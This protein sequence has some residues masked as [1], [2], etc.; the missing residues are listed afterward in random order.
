MKIGLKLILIISAVNLVGIG[1]L[2]IAATV[3]SSREIT[4][5][6]DLDVGHLTEVTAKEVKAFLE[7]PL[8][9][10]R[11]MVNLMSAIDEIAPPEGRREQI[12]F[13]LHTMIVKHPD[14]VGVW[15]IYEP[16]ALDGRDAA[17]VNSEWSDQTG[18][19]ISYWTNDKGVIG[20][21]AVTGYTTAEYYTV[22]MRTGREYLVEPYIE[23]IGGRKTLITSVT[24]PIIVAGKIVG[25]AGV[26]LEL[27]EIQEMIIK[28]KPFGDGYA[29][30]Y[31]SG[32]LI[33]S[34]P[35]ADRLGRKIEDASKGL[36]GDRT[37]AL[38]RS[39]KEGVV[40]SE[41]LYSSDHN[42]R[43]IVVTRP[44]TTGNDQD[45]WMAV[46]VVP[47]NTVMAE[48]RRMTVFLAI[49]GVAILGI[50]TVIILFVA[51]SITAP[52]NKME[53]VFE[54]IGNGDFTHV[55]E[56]KGNDEIGNISRSLNVT[57][58]KIKA[59]INV[60]KIQASELSGIGTDLSSNMTETAAAINEI[61]ANIQSIKTRAINQSASV[62]ETNAT[63]EQI[64]I[65]ISKLNEQVEKQTTSVSQ[66]SSAIEEMLANIQSVTQTL[67]KNMENVNALTSASEVGRSGLQDVAQDI[68]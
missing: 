56:T 2:T 50:I 19:F 49:L 60:I 59:L 38:L 28:I 65:N 12:E 58:D 22:P 44:F 43:M 7:V 48:L 1:G 8:D 55:I 16:N 51:R 66:S 33:V 63:M 13:M 21:S 62:S 14:Y 18:R 46:T 11:S 61:T 52:L 26:D 45:A 37:A 6:A 27:T 36:F 34:H 20:H 57:V 5:L 39:L 41:T 53:G 67:M 31:S 23:T 68:Q 40:F 3:F 32:G 10:M 64:T 24:V 54:F 15:A 17:Y 47:Y 42:A 4:K 30:I 9:E 35:V 29:A 25:V